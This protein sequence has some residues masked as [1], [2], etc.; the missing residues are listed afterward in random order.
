MSSLQ[1]EVAAHAVERLLDPRRTGLE[2]MTPE[3][4]RA[5]LEEAARKGRVVDRLPGGALEVLWQGVYVVI[6]RG[7]ERVAVLT[8][9][10]DRAWRSWYRKKCHRPRLTPKA[11]A[12][13]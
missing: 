4:A 8:V 11:L 1:V 12:A 13:L 6:R 2:G 7:R 9:N 5:F 3:E 10:G